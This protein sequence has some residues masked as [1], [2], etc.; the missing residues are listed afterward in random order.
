MG[1]INEPGGAPGLGSC[2]AVYAY[3]GSSLFSY[4][5]YSVVGS[6]AALLRWASWTDVANVDAAIQ[7]TIRDTK[8]K[9]FQ[10]WGLL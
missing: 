7:Q 3:L 5:Q 9:V 8:T 10:I 1:A 6:E 4:L 2:C